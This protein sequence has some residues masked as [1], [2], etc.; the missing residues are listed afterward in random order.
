MPFDDSGDDNENISGVRGILKLG[1]GDSVV[2]FEGELVV[3]WLVLP[4]SIHVQQYGPPLE[5]NETICP[6]YE[7]IRVSTSEGELLY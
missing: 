3:C 2:Q 7:R 6:S 4:C 5:K 1:D